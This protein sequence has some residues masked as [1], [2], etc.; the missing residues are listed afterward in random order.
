MS[1]YIALVI[2]FA[3]VVTACSKPVDKSTD[4]PIEYDLVV[5]P[6]EDFPVSEAWKLATTAAKDTG[7]KIKVVLP[8][9]TRDWKPFPEST[10]Y[11]PNALVTIALPAVERLKSN[12]GGKVYVILTCQDIGPPDGSLK[13]VF[14]QHDHTQKISVISTARILFDQNNDHTAPNVVQTRLRKLFLRAVALQYYGLQ[15]SA[16]ITDVTCLPLMSVSDLDQ[17]GL[18]I[19]T[20]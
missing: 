14:T 18:T 16:D 15:R 2:S 12:Y 4:E 17:M 20:K 19:K 11:D 13:F 5:V 7:L 9:G 10:Q 6:T 8:L 1:L 3:A